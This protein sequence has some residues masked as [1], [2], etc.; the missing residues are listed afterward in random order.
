MTHAL[1]KPGAPT[2][3]LVDDSPEMLILLE[4]LLSD[5]YNIQTA[6][7]GSE[8][9]EWLG[10]AGS[11]PDLILLDCLMPGMDG[12]Q[13][14][15]EIRRSSASGVPVVFLSALSS[16]EE[17][18]KG[19][20]AGGDDYICKPFDMA[21][22]LAK[23][24]RHIVAAASKRELD[25]QLND[26]VNAVMSS[27]D[28]V[29]E[30]GVVL[31]FQRQLNSTNSY[32]GIAAHLFGAFER[33]NL[34][35]CVRISGQMGRISQNTKGNCTALEASILDHIEAQGTEPHIRPFGNHTS[36][37]FG[38]VILFLRD[39]PMNRPADMPA[40]LSERCGRQIDNVA[41][42]AE[43]ATTKVQALDNQ[44][45]V[46][47]LVGLNAEIVG[48]TRMA[49]ADISSRNQAQSMRMQ[50]LFE[51]LSE[52]LNNSFIHL[53]LL[54]EQEDALA[55]MVGRY[56]DKALAALVKGRETEAKLGE[57]IERLG[58]LDR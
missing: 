57:V 53:G 45:A 50:D 58:T 8:A 29:G 13:T 32:Q 1:H 3:L 48:A 37:N 36:F 14:C 56:K 12:Y 16:I 17:R 6:S 7:S 15:Q 20:S 52:E 47:K 46:H 5:R 33:Y 27:A 51:A 54:P 25:Q 4:E 11:L 42:L 41:L 44:Q 10:S 2:L 39:L 38:S 22:L 34:D 35:G 21:E 40:E 18:L 9:M 26:A 31:D 55:S 30:V 43:G 23:I 24:E 19:Y 49:L 28:M